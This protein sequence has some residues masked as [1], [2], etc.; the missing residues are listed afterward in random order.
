MVIHKEEF[1]QKKWALT[2][3]QLRARGA[4][5]EVVKRLKVLSHDA[6]KA[7]QQESKINGTR[8]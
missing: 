4:Y 3:N 5:G 8:S 1:F 6:A 7:V 2:V